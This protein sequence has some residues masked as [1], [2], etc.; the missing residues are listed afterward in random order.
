M[1]ASVSV[2]VPCRNEARY[3]GGFLASLN[4]QEL[5]GGVTLEI[6]IAD[7]ESDDG[8]RE[9]LLRFAAQAPNVRV[10]D[11]PRRIVS[12][13][14]NLAIREASGDTIIRMD[15]HAEYAPD[16]IRRCLEA[17][18]QPGID[19][20]GG[21][22]RT[23]SKGYMQSAIAAAY[24]SPFTC[25]G[26]RFHDVAYEGPVDTV[27]F[28]CWKKQ[29]LLELGLFDEDLIRNQDDELNLRLVRKGGVIWQT[30]RIRCWYHPRS[31]LKT[32]FSQY[33]QY[34]YWKVRVIRKHGKPAS[35]RHLVPAT[36]VGLASLLLLLA[37]VSVA[38]REGSIVLMGSYLVATIIAS[39]AICLPAK[40]RLLPIMPFVVA[41]YHIAYGSGFLVGLFASALRV[42][43]PPGGVVLDRS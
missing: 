4:E 3:V 42:H 33:A 26:A 8:T 43:K 7:G 19:N 40:L 15:V 9:L 13:G 10:L 28:G 6:L 37:S 31:S 39:L 11:N 12:S 35:L 1:S 2:V 23:R 5:P 22:A 20:V 21:P 34:G 32:L 38:A 16:Y 24:H 27:T 18:Q 41:T 36:F 30:S 17:L 25:G 14:L 29:T